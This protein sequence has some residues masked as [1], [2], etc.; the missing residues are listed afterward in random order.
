[1]KHIRETMPAVPEPIQIVTGHQLPIPSAFT[2]VKSHTHP[3]SRPSTANNVD[4]EPQTANLKHHRQITPVV[5]DP[6]PPPN[7]P[8]TPI[9]SAR[10]LIN[11]HSLY[12]RH[13]SGRQRHMQK[14]K[15]NT[16]A[17][18]AHRV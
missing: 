6:I 4:T 7:I 16:R 12:T 10:A 3:P 14:Q 5:H 11:P 17:Q 18:K 1:M 2:L 8:S 13:P 9:P 15:R